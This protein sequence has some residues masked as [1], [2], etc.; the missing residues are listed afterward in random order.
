[1]VLVNGHTPFEHAPTVEQ[2]CFVRDNQRYPDDYTLKHCLRAGA[3]SFPDWDADFAQ[4][5]VS[6][7]QVPE[8]TIVKK[9][10]RG[11]FS[12]LGIIMGLASRA[13]ITF[14]DEPYLG[15]DATAR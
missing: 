2:M 12:A 11:Q 6:R 13:P 15:L 8:K 7:F 3:I 1:Q 14:F 4:K 9:Y 10:S 5:L